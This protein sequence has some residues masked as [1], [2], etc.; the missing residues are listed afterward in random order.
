MFKTFHLDYEKNHNLV[1]I[2]AEQLSAQRSREVLTHLQLPEILVG[3]GVILV[4]SMETLRE[5]ADVLGFQLQDK[6]KSTTRFPAGS[7][8]AARSSRKNQSAAVID[9]SASATT[10][11]IDI[12]TTNS[13]SSSSSACTSSC[14]GPSVRL[15]VGV[16]AE[17]KATMINNRG[18][19]ALEPGAALLQVRYI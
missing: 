2:T 14:N 9:N 4:N 10:A 15:Y 17:W 7:V 5:A 16:D 6:G 18:H 8:K 19:P 3:S 1:K 13:S 11:S 12:S